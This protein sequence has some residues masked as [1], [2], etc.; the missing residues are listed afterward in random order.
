MRYLFITLSSFFCLLLIWCELQK[1]DNGKQQISTQNSWI[2]TPL[3]WT[4]ERFKRASTKFYII[5]GSYT[6]LNR[7]R[8][9]YMGD[10]M[11]YM[12]HV[13]HS[14]Y[15]YYFVT[16]G[17][18]PTIN[19]Q[20]L[21]WWD[22]IWWKNTNVKAMYNI[23]KRGDPE[24]EKNCELNIE[25]YE[26]GGII[27][28]FWYSKKTEQLIASWMGN[29]AIFKCGYGYISCNN[30]SHNTQCTYRYN[31]KTGWW[32]NGYEIDELIVL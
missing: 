26:Q 12:Y 29:D 4:E 24:L 11:A 20:E 17:E 10:A 23:L 15:D 7:N 13:E 30:D 9:E 8:Q 22:V 3:K 5:T 27:A 14:G 6:A 28:R 25:Y 31:L 19:N 18:M 2:N 32:N 21:N 1:I 16:D